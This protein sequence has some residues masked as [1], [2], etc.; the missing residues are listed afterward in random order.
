MN[1]VLV[2]DEHSVYRHGLRRLLE[3]H[4][5]Q[6]RVMEAKSLE[7]AVVTQVSFDLML[8]DAAS[9]G[10]NSSGTLQRIRS[11]HPQ[12][13]FAVISYSQTRADAFKFLSAG[14]H[15]F[16]CKLQPD[17]E[18]LIGVD[19][20]LSGKIYVPGWIMDN[21]LFVQSAGDVHATAPKLTPRQREILPLLAAG[22][23]TKEI[24]REMGIAAGTVKIHTTAVL[25]ALGARNRTEAAF[26][27]AKLILRRLDER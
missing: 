18:L 25:R 21:A 8:I 24:A 23:S 7:E 12:T 2:I 4:L 17:A 6:S 14:F 27:S 26:L 11:I 13:H 5:A 15:G 3:T 10:Y 16:L 22:M 1:A 9:L 20:L 19:D